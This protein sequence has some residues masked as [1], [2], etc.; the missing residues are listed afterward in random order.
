M[1]ILSQDIDKRN[2]FID[3]ILEQI[4]LWGYKTFFMLSLTEHE[5]IMLINVKMPTIV[6]ILTLLAG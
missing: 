3:E 6:G 5:C 1:F 4:R 2:G